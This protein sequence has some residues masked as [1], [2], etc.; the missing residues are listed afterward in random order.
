[1]Y[2]FFNPDNQGRAEMYAFVQSLIIWVELK[3]MPFSTLIIR[4]GLKCMPLFNPD[5]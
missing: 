3:C 2:A 5:N 1:M 4:V